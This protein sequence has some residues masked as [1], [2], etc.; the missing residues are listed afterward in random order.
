MGGQ[1]LAPTLMAQCGSKIHDFRLCRLRFSRTRT[2]QKKRGGNPSIIHRPVCIQ[3]N[4]EKRSKTGHKTEKPFSIR[5]LFEPF[6]CVRYCSRPMIDEDVVKCR[7]S[8]TDSRPCWRF[9]FE[10]RAFAAFFNF[11]FGNA[12]LLLADSCCC[13]RHLLF[14][15][16]SAH[17]V[18]T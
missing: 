9:L 5:P 4:K 11:T 1:L 7:L 14:K 2:N 13:Q 10:L 18:W 12:R 15:Y 6:D 3:W 16:F 17:Y 8:S